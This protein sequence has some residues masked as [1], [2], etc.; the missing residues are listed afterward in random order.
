[1]RRARSAVLCC[2]FLL[3]AA[4]PGSSNAGTASLAAT[5]LVLEI[6]INGANTNV[7]TDVVK[8]DGSW[9]VSRSDLNNAGINVNVMP[10]V[11][12]GLVSLARVSGVTADIDGADQR[13]LIS[14]RAD[15]LAPRL[16]SLRRAP[17]FAQPSSATGM[18]ASYD[19]TA[20]TSDFGHAAN[21]SGVDAALGAIFFAPLGTVNATAYSQV[22]DGM[23]RFVRLDTTAE[24]DELDVPRR[25]LAGDAISGGLSWSRSVRFGGLQIATDF[26][27]QPGR[28]TIP[29]PVFFGQTAVPGSVDVFVNSAH[30][31]EGDLQP[32]PFE[33]RDLPVVT[34]GGEATVVVR[35]ILGQETTQSFSFYASDAL[36]AQ[37]LSSYDLDVGFLRESYGEKSFDYGDPL[38][39][40]TWCYGLANWLT[41]EA[42]G[43]AASQA[44]L[45][46][47][48]PALTVASYGVIGADVAASNSRLGQGALFSAFFD[49]QSHPFGAFGSVSATRGGYADLASIGG[50]LPPRLRTQLGADASLEPR[51]SVAISWIS[52]KEYGQAAAQLASASYTVSFAHGWYF[53]ATGLHDL[54]NGAWAAQLTLSIPLVPDLTASTSVEAGAG[55]NEVEAGVTRSANPDGGLGYNVSASA[56]DVRSATGEV[57]WIGDRSTVDAGVSS[58][59]GRTAGRVSASGALVA[60]NGST[61]LTRNPN[62]AVALVE[63]GNA[64]VPVY[65]ENRQV[66]VSDSD[67]EALLTG[68]A[69]DASNRIGIEPTDYAFSTVVSRTQQNVVPR[70][71]SG[72]VVDLAPPR[73][74]PALIILRAED[75]AAPPVGS[76]VTL[77]SGGVTLLVGHDGQIFIADLESRTAGTVS[78]PGGSCRFFVDPPGDVTKDSIPRMGPIPCAKEP[79][80]GN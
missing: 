20:M 75:G 48:G 63:T 57:M 1:M 74:R 8:R 45:L 34:G 62:G 50:I 29:L 44:Q 21:T 59:D 77:A 71:L 10:G 80:N 64:D 23:Q 7:V 31:F 17:E 67:G 2:W 73:S 15:C 69:P 9:W 66:A 22:Q 52:D 39:T 12:H 40:G 25:W 61:F 6:W 51:G 38:V 36:L 58:V 11:E 70:R 16:L 26:S 41:V 79:P 60:M 54:S 35:N 24:W 3:A 78:W 30:V 33:L 43:E 32:G 47:G 19:V 13:L 37:G 14:A 4:C 53:G 5:N 49:S 56:G 27:L 68:L 55:N 46:G 28:A 76:E 72:V 65:L 18:I 42:H